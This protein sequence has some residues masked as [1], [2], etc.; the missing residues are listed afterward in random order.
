MNAHM[1]T[2]PTALAPLVMSFVAFAIVIGHIVFVGTAREADEGAAAH[3]F[4][5]LM[6]GQLPIIAFFAIKWLQR[7]PK[8]ALAVLASQAMAG[9]VACVPV[10]YFNL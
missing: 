2:R 1:F 7:A 10:W 3:L 6:A 8:Q 9:V 4:Q 5:L